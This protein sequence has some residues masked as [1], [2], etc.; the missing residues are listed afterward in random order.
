MEIVISGGSGF[1]GSHLLEYFINDNNISK[2]HIIDIVPPSIVSNKIIYYQND[3]RKKINISLDSDS[4]N[5]CYH[6]AALAKEPCYTWEEYFYTNYLGTKNVIEFC[7]RNNIKKIIFTSTMMVYKAK[8][9][10]FSEEDIATPDTA[11]GI[12]KLL[13]EE[14]LLTWQAK[15]SNRKLTIYRIGVV[16]GFGENGN[17]TRLYNALKKKYFFYIGKKNTIKSSVYVKDVVFALKFAN[18]KDLRE[19]IYNLAIPKELTISNIVNAIKGAF[20]FTSYTF[21]VPYKI[22]LLGGY[23]F[24]FFSLLGFKTNIHH[25]RIQKLFYS[26]NIC[27][28]RIL[29]EG[30]KFQYSLEDAINDW[31]KDCNN[32]GLF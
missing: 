3:I 5:C 31:K 9:Y 19:S 14:K 32:I 7:E 28:D 2:I 18:Y 24:E 22:A 17:Y 15:D 30:F 20:N 16:F 10:R 8:E 23:F 27:S 11:Y 1:I 21:I 29:S 12:S 6:L 26:T 4:I 13:A 25:R